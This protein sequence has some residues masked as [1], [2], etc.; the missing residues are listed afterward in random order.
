[1][2]D[3]EISAIKKHFQGCGYGIISDETAR[4]QTD[5]LKLMRSGKYKELV[6]NERT[7]KAT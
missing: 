2:N 1:M 7:I 6:E 5:L 4:A 3:E